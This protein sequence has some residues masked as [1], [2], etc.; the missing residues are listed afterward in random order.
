MPIAHNQPAARNQRPPGIAR[1]QRR[2]R[3][4]HAVQQPTAA[5]AQGAAQRADDPGRDGAG[6]SQRIAD[7]DDKLTNAQRCRDAKFGVRQAGARQAKNRDIGRRIVADERRVEALA[8]GQARLQA[9]GPRD[10]M[11]VGEDIAVRSEDHAR[12]LPSRAAVRGERGDMHDRGTDTVERMY[13]LCGI[14]IEILVQRIEG[15]GKYPFAAQMGRILS[16][17]HPV[18]WRGFK[19]KAAPPRRTTRL[20]EFK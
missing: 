6:E 9:G 19:W 16:Q 17:W 2:V 15:H 12:P 3:L 5:G 7:G 20:S 13:H 10:D 4:D 14:R 1:V 18:I 8:I 11:A